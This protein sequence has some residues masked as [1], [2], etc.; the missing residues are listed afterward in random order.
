MPARRILKIDVGAMGFGPLPNPNVNKL[1]RAATPT[2]ELEL[3]ARA[4]ATEGGAEAPDIRQK[5]QRRQKLAVGA[6]RPVLNRMEM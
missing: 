2:D 3:A 6:R 4:G 1:E 5:Q